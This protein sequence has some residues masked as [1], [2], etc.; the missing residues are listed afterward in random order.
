M[1]SGHHLLAIIDLF[2]RGM[3]RCTRHPRPRYSARLGTLRLPARRANTYGD[4]IPDEDDGGVSYLPE[5]PSAAKPQ[6]G[7]VVPLRRGRAG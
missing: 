4:W 5:P 1:L 6:A 3:P 7:S 2:R